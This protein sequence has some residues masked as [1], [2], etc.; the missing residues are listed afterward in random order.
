MHH[1]GV[2]TVDGGVTIDENVESDEPTHLVSSPAIDR[3]R[4]SYDIVAE[5]YANDL[6]DEMVA[7][8]FE[9]GMLLAFSEL[10]R[11]LG[12]GIVGDVGCGPGHIAKHL[13]SLGVQVVGIDIS[14]AMIAQ[15]RIKFAAGEFRVGSMFHLGESDG[16]WL[17]VIAR[18]ATLHSSRDERLQA[19]RE[20]HRVVRPGGFLSC[21]F[22]E[23][24]P[25]QPPGSIYHLRSWFGFNV[26]L[27]TYFVAVEDAAA[28]LEQCGFE[29]VAALVREP[30]YSNELPARR[31]TIVAKRR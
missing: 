5:R 19:Y 17:G 30:L 12:P 22:Y 21:C 29:V 9:R 7:R 8:P 15:A 18:Y 6:A 27:T 10:V 1:S 24:A 11:P 28:E 2:D 25:D 23:S 26:D 16:S 3:V 31:C 20:W 13:A 4:A 14:A